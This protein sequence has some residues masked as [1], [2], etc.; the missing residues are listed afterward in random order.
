M[1]HFDDDQMITILEKHGLPD[2][3]TRQVVFHLYE[4]VFGKPAG[5]KMQERLAGAAD[6]LVL[7]AQTEDGT[8]TGFKVGYRQDLFTWYS[9]LGG[10]LPEFRGQ[11]I[12]GALMQHQHDW[13]KNRGYRRIQTKT[14]NRWRSML[15]L[16]LKFGFNVIGTYQ[17]IDGTLRIILEKRL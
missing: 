8:P 11:G 3:D 9:W 16:N 17:G 1:R 2:D 5:E 6:L 10:V 14:M 15:I 13:A 4:A 7:I 12:A